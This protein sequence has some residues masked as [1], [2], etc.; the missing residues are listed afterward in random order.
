MHCNAH[1]A[2]THT[3][4]VK[5]R[6]EMTC[7]S[8]VTAL[9]CATL[10][11]LLIYTVPTIDAATTACVHYS[12]GQWRA[13]SHSTEKLSCRSTMTR[14]RTG[15]SFTSILTQVYYQLMLCNSAK[16]VSAAVTV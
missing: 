11:L 7:T 6:C 9:H 8:H 4:V 5:G 10:A 15:L 13:L 12:K 16:T 14:K 2:V 1:V 3:T